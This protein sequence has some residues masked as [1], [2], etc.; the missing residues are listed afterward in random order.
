MSSASLS[1]AAR[2]VQHQVPRTGHFPRGSW[3]VQRLVF[4]NHLTRDDPT[5]DRHMI[6]Q[7]GFNPAEGRRLTEC[8]TEW[9]GD[10]ANGK[11]SMMPCIAQSRLS[12]NTIPT[13]T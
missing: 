6:H 4:A 7:E 1:C 9:H 5:G 12:W 2:C 10:H 8:W 13:D 11:R 3:R